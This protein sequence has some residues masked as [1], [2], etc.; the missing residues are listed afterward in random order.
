MDIKDLVEEVGYV[1][2][3]KAS[4]HGGE[5]SAP[6]PFC[7][8][9]DD[10]FLIWPNKPNQ[11]GELQGGR[12]SC[13]V[14]GK[15]GDAINFLRDLYGLT[16]NEACEKLRIQP[17]ER[18]LVPVFREKPKPPSVNDPSSL[19][20]EKGLGFI[21]WSH[22]QLLNNPAALSEVTARGFTMESIVK[23]KLGFCPST[24]YR[25]REDWG[26][27]RELKEDGKPRRLWLP[28]GQTI[29]TF[30]KDGRVTKI[31]VRRTYWK[32]GDKL[33]KYVEISGSKQAPSIYG[34]TSIP[35]SI[36][37][38][39]EFDAL[40]IQQFTSDLV[41]CVAL[42]GSTKNPDH[43]TDQL[44]R[45]TQLLLFCP[46]FDKPGAIA[47]S[48]WKDMFPQIHKILTPDGKGAGDY[49]QNG[50]DL[51]QWLEDSVKEIQRKINIK[52]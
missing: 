10:R 31:K 16:Y 44:L 20:Q 3:K 46:D 48:K 32:N 19:W 8:E 13:R 12:F 37:L 6:C 17:K 52:I 7:K 30:S 43:L 28:M 42:G 25:D 15:Y 22:A 51:R 24:F 26:L 27:I 35:C 2:K 5:Y 4:T 21:E 33:P 50:G 18:G 40:L 47:W 1:P 45:S 36:I 9:G 38:E 29:P 39:S 34:D 41:Y 14:C 49:F 23:F 11:K